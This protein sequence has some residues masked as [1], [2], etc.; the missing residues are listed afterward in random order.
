MRKLILILLFLIPAIKAQ[1][2]NILGDTNIVSITGVDTGDVASV[3]GI[4]W[5]GL[6][7]AVVIVS[8]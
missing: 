8:K 4:S 2:H 5:L 6:L 3:N 7:I 1:T